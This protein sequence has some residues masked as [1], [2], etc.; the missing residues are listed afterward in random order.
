MSR[1]N[2]YRGFAQAL[3]EWKGYAARTLLHGRE[4]DFGYQ[5]A[6][7]LLV[8]EGPKRLSKRQSGEREVMALVGDLEIFHGFARLPK[9]CVS[10]AKVKG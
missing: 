3:T 1:A 6:K 5:F 2:V 9:S 8:V 7:I 4:P 10:N